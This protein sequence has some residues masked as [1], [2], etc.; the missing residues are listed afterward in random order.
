MLLIPCSQQVAVRGR[1]RKSRRR[2]PLFKAPRLQLRSQGSPLQY[3][4]SSRGHPLSFPHT[5]GALHR[6]TA[7]HCTVGLHGTALQG[8]ERGVEPRGF[9]DAD[10]PESPSPTARVQGPAARVRAACI[11][12][13]QTQTAPEKTLT[14]GPRTNIRVIQ[15]PVH[16]LKGT[17]VLQIEPK[18][19][20]NCFYTQRR[21]RDHTGLVPTYHKWFVTN[22]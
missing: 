15:V 18:L 2:L 8:M 12:V 16:F 4:L 22:P 20:D 21:L 19:C 11:T 14:P 5:R 6:G 17:E 10:I 1:R 13:D 3:K 9:C 7:R